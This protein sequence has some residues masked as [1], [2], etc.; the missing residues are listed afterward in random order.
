[1]VETCITTLQDVNLMIQ[2]ARLMIQTIDV[3][4]TKGFYMPGFLIQMSI[5]TSSHEFPFSSL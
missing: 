2:D 3:E 5:D 1:M 4:N